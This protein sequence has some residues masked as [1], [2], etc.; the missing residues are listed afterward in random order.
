MNNNKRIIYVLCSPFCK[1]GGTELLHQLVYELNY[2]GLNSM[3]VYTISKEKKYL[4][5]AFKEY[6]NDYCIENDIIDDEKNILIIPEVCT[7]FINRFNKIKTYLWWLSVDNYISKDI[8]NLW[9]M[10][11]GLKEEYIYP[12]AILIFIRHLINIKHHKTRAL[13]IVK[14]NRVELHLVQSQYAFDF[15]KENG[16]E[17]I[18]FLS[19]YIN[20]VYIGQR[21]SII[22]EDKENIVLYNPKKGKHFTRKI[23]R[24][25]NGVRFVPLENM[26]NEQIIELLKK[27]KLYIDFGG[28]PGK[29]R[30]PREAAIMKCCIIT[31]KRGA[32]NYQDVL[33]DEEFKFEDKEKNI[34]LIAEMII[35]ILDDYNS[36]IERFE[37]YR[38]MI[39][40]ERQNFETDVRRIFLSE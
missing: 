15:L 3:I 19:D 13:P 34:P 25:C 7:N 20:D 38:N 8:S 28:H 6:V 17:K 37:K 33:I 40:K 23:M 29:D 18:E 26:T 10:L 39:S 2:L 11:K 9:R 31:G 14:M 35:K 36:Y 21:D 27:A 30:F 5:P 24:K 32:A 1:T 22:I 4:N 16:V 12:K